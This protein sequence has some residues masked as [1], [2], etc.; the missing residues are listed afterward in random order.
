[1]PI[2]YAFKIQQ[3]GV[4]LYVTTM[5]ASDLLASYKIDRWG[6]DNPK[7]YQ[8]A[9]VPIR[10]RKAMNYLLKEEG[11]FPTSILVNVRGKVRF[12]SKWKINGFAEFG[13]LIISPDSLPFSIVD[14]QHRLEGLKAAREEDPT[15]DNYPVPVTIINLP[16]VYD[17][18]RQF[19][20]INTR[21]KGVPTD[22][23]Q[24]H[25]YEMSVKMG[26]PALMALEGEKAVLTAEAIPIVDILR[27]DP[28]SPWY[29]KVQLPGERKQ[30]HH[31]IKQRPLAD[32]ITYIL[33]ARPSFRRKKPEELANDLI[34]YWNAIKE[35]FPEAFENPK[36]YTIQKTP[37]TYSLHMVYPY[38]Y[39]LC[40]I[41]DDYSQRKMKE[42]LTKM[43]QNV[44]AAIPVDELDS[45]FW[46]REE[47]HP[48][49]R[50]TS[51][52]MIK[53]LAEYFLQALNA[54]MEE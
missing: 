37:G 8:R 10:V 17:E 2:L 30:K 52:K 1:M 3:R 31:V 4:P 24:R 40:E 16:D 38:V 20:I 50:A 51:M 45:S 23:V 42:I 43:F 46:H 5:K 48:L 47:G 34:K 35:I 22:L 54:I 32:S 49:A 44:A 26:K 6:E 41:A 14:G 18:M 7:G 27:K 28:N 19:Y 15:L 25:L 53:A 29:D 39:E 12:K 9:L 11:V 21:Q 36:E 13:E 33:K